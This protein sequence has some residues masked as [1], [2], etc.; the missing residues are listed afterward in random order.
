MVNA[1]TKQQA[2]WLKK[3]RLK[4]GS[5]V[6]IV[7]KAEDYENGWWNTWVESMDE[8]VGKEGKIVSIRNSDGI[9]VSVNGT[10]R[11]TLRVKDV[12]KGIEK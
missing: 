5:T 8:E 3:H 1:Y 7:K 4:V 9:E 12:W 6:K 11:D 10:H 2:N